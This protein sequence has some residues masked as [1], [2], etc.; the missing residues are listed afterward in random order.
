[1]E[2]VLGMDAALVLTTEWV[3]H[4]W[5]EVTDPRVPREELPDP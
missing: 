2:A 5:A 4:R 1:M 3:D